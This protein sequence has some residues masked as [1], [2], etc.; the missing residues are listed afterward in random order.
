[1]AVWQVVCG[2]VGALPPTGVF[3]RTS[4]NQLNGATHPV[5]QVLNLSSK[6]TN[7]MYV[8]NYLVYQFLAIP[9][10]SPLKF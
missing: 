8:S 1:M 5:S 6:V 3:V 9:G 7:A 4:V 2:V 10:S